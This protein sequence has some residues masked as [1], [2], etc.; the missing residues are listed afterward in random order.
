[1]PSAYAPALSLPTVWNSGC[2]HSQAASVPVSRSGSTSTG[3]W[4]SMSIKMV[5]YDCPGGP[6]SHPRPA[7]LSGRSLGQVKRGSAGSACH[8]STAWRASTRACRASASAI[9]TSASVSGGVRRPNGVV[10]PGICSENVDCAHRG[11]THLN[12][13]ICAIPSPSGRRAEGRRA[14]ADSGREPGTSACGIPEHAASLAF[15]RT[16]NITTS[17]PSSTLSTVAAANCGE[18]ASMACDVHV[19]H[20]GRPLPTLHVRHAGHHRSRDHR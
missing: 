9:L 19:G 5:L 16:R 3:L 10:S 1:M 6:R 2:S 8:G 13:R 4:L 20:P 14:D 17:S 7:P 18:S 12:R 15:A 11:L